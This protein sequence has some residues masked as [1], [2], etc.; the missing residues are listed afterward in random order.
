MTAEEKKNPSQVRGE[1]DAGETPGKI[2]GFDPSAAPLETD[3]EAASDETDV[4]NTQRR[5]AAGSADGTGRNAS[6]HA[7]AMRDAP[8]VQSPP[9]ERKPMAWFIAAV[10][11]IVV[12]AIL[13]ALAL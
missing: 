8:F 10:V 11:G 5:D 1:I 6:S 7:D 13:I 4:L 12:L 3:S 9:A 2:S